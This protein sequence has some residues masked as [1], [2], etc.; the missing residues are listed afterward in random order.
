[1]NHH[2]AYILISRYIKEQFGRVVEL[3]QVSV[4]R[5][6]AGRQWVGELYRVTQY[7]DVRVGSVAMDE[8][9]AVSGGL[10]I[11]DLIDTLSQVEPLDAISLSSRA[12]EDVCT[13]DLAELAEEDLYDTKVGGVSTP[14]EFEEFFVGL[15]TPGLRR[16]IAQLLQAKTRASL[17]QAR[18]KLPLLLPN[19]EGRAEVLRQMAELELL[20][21]DVDVSLTYFE[22]AARELADHA[23]LKSLERASAR[24]TEIVG[25]THA[26][27]RSIDALVRQTRLRMKPIKELGD[28]PVFSGLTRT[29]LSA[30]GDLSTLITVPSGTEIIR[31]EE[32]PFRAFV[33]R[34]GVVSIWIEAP[35][36]GSRFVR[37][38][39]PGEFIGESSV[40]GGVGASATAT[41]RAQTRTT[42]WQFEGSDLR[43]L[44]DTM[45]EL[46]QRLQHTQIRH[47][48]DSFFSTGSNTAGLDVRVRDRLLACLEG[49]NRLAE[50]ELVLAG[51]AVPN[52]VYLVLEGEL[53]Y[54][55]GQTVLRSAR[56][57]G[58]VAL[59]HALH[60]VPLEGE[61]RARTPARVAR[62][63]ARALQALADN[64]P[65]EVLGIL[66]TLC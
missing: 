18:E 62:F 25:T 27:A 41:V 63:D 26:R 47:R 42:L 60:R 7:G 51:G 53:T 11:D 30:I 21:G 37:C 31:E 9:G 16:E 10:D 56:P 55:S 22:A 28:A 39:F 32:T 4:R 36:G 45:R 64:A 29:A 33:I 61:W 44:S 38:C 3:R 65:A 8:S 52:T 48:L 66:E 12:L 50:G 54:V 19:P 35:Q 59:R 40:L 57:S 20:L 58:F 6:P 24:V 49:V 5:H 2:T 15:D 46:K 13:I 14:D 17:F 43:D 34:S 1:M 23:D